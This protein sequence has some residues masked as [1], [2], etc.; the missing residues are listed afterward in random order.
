MNNDFNIKNYNRKRHWHRL[1]LGLV[2]VLHHPVL[3]LALLLP[4]LFALILGFAR[5]ELLTALAIP[6][7][8]EPLFS[9]C[10]LFAVIVVPILFAVLI[11]QGI[12]EAAAKKIEAKILLCFDDKHLRHGAPLLVSRKY[13][14]SRH[15]YE[16][17]SYIPMSVWCDKKDTLADMLDCRII[18]IDYGKHGDRVVLTIAK[19]RKTRVE[20]RIYDE[21]L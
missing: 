1:T 15:Y 17:Q 2:Q 19:G 20:R 6:S 14:A 9:G 13:K 11:L 10:L 4:I 7:A 16:F 21:H 5:K 8:L 12:G 3:F 18:S